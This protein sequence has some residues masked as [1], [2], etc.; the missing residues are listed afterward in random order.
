MEGEPNTRNDILKK[1]NRS[2]SIIN[3]SSHTV[4]GGHNIRIVQD[5]DKDSIVQ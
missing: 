5:K 2:R 3:F 4:K 1:V